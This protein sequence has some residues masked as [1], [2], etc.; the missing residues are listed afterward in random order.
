MNAFKL[1]F[2]IAWKN[3]ILSCEP[4]VFFQEICFA[5]SEFKIKDG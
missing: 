2:L 3:K 1:F 5:V 4:I